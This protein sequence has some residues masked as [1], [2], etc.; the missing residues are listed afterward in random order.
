MKHF[1]LYLILLSVSGASAQLTLTNG[2]HTLE[3]SGSVSAYYNYRAL[4]DGEFEKDKDRFKLRDA[5]LQLEGRIGNIWEYELQMDFADMS[6]NN[7][8]AQPDPENPGLMDAYVKYKGLKLFDV[9]VGYGKLFYSRSSMV[10]FAYSPYWQRA[11]LVRGD[12]FSQRDVG[13]TIMKD[14]LNQRLNV[15]AGIYTGLGEL[16]LQGD[17]DASGQPEYA[18]RVDFSYPSRF[19]YRDID[20]RITP[21]PMFT[22]GI[23]ARYANKTLPEGEVFPENAEGEYGLKVINGKKYVYG[24]DA[25]FQYMGFSGQFEMHQVKGE[26]ALA[27]DPLLHNLAAA[28]TGGYFLSGG[29]VAQLNY[30]AK[31]IRTILS[32]RYEELDL[33]DLVKGNSRRFS[34]AIAYQIDGFD[35]MI[36]FQYFN[37]LKEEAV[38]PFKWKEQFRLGL[39]LNFK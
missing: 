10:P 18:A 24:F 13:V 11:D 35:A 9:Q 2:N 1:Y 21:I 25:A 39:Q 4:K 28:Q 17:N 36:K 23:N 32:A 12:I 16:S 5:Q 6:A 27:N 31:S 34:P 37:I 15:Y 26:P 8:N 33:N 19:R 30:F 3:I 20:D 22:I 38:D 7:S 14:F 29:Y